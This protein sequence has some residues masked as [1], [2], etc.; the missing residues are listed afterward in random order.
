MK[1]YKHG[2]AVM[3]L[4]PLHKGHEA[5]INKMKDE[6]EDVTILIGSADKKRTF[7]NPFTINERHDMLTPY[8]VHSISLVDINR[9]DIWVKYVLGTTLLICPNKP[10]PD[11]Y[12]AGSMEDAELFRIEGFPIELLIRKKYSGTEVRNTMAK[13]GNKWRA[14]LPQHSQIIVEKYLK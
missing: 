8:S 1:K 4:Q 11:V 12:Y 10:I 9:P 5:L 13:G 3:R 7:A 14:M 6:C 2:I